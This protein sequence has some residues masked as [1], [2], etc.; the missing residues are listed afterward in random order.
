MNQLISE[1]NKG[2]CS[3]TYCTRGPNGKREVV[4]V[5]DTRTPAYCSQSCAQM[6]QRYKNRYKGTLNGRST[7][8]YLAEKMKKV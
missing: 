3:N 7:K 6:M 8:E 2:L 1:V 5:R 4:A